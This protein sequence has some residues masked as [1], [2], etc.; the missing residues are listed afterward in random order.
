M[1]W[2]AMEQEMVGPLR[3]RR[4]RLARLVLL[5]ELFEQVAPVRRSCRPFDGD[6]LCLD[7]EQ[8]GPQLPSTKRGIAAQRMAGNSVVILAITAAE[9]RC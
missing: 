2:A 6:V 3:L 8:Q 7:R 4:C 5:A 9:Q 1:L